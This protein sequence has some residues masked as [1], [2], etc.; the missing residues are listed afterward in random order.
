MGVP[1]YCVLEPSAVRDLLKGDGSE[2]V[3]FSVP[4][5]TFSRLVS[6]WDHMVDGPVHDQWRKAMALALSPS[7]IERYLPALEKTIR[8]ALESWE[9]QG[10]VPLL[11]ACGD[12]ALS[13]AMDVLIGVELTHTDR[14]WFKQQ[15]LL[16]LEGLY[17]LY[18]PFP[19]TTYS[20]AQV[21]KANVIAALVKE[22]E[23][24]VQ[25]TL[26]ADPAA[27]EAAANASVFRHLDGAAK[28]RL[29]LSQ[30][31]YQLDSDV[32]SSV[33]ERLKQLESS[34]PASNTDL[35]PAAELEAAIGS[36][37]GITLADA[38][39][40]FL[41]AQ[42]RLTLES[43]AGRILGLFAAA[44]DTSRLLI[45]T[46]LAFLAQLPEEV[47]KLREEQQQVI[48]RHGS[49]LTPAVLSELVYL[50]GVIKETSRLLSASRVAVR[51]AVKPLQ[52]NGVHI[53]AD[54]YLLYSVDCMHCL[55]PTLWQGPGCIPPGRDVPP[56]MDWR[57]NLKEA[58]QPAR[59][60]PGSP[61]KPKHLLTFGAGS[62]MCLGMNLVYAEFK[63]LL[64]VMVRDY[65]WQFSDPDVLKCMAVFPKLKPARGSDTLLIK[66]R[67]LH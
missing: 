4:F 2:A 25:Q 11:E 54:A 18:L 36:S 53:P 48:S 64:S 13:F 21:A 44:V 61:N 17:T 46:A 45:F 7:S 27:G 67:H 47:D 29:L 43:A 22:L 37:G 38:Q 14:S 30:Q 40:E 12:M 10:A 28:C 58:F 23:E 9:R 15:I 20:K 42:R 39:F 50:E 26:Q 5:A 66:R 8:E 49:A 56:Y 24:Q 65:S 33:M 59:W 34:A 62:H 63:L 32:V 60:L 57:C 16:T 3:T 35:A 52:L 19:G 55:E 6:D 1:M 31:E 51:Q 41:R